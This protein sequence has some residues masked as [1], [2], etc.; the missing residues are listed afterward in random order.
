MRNPAW[1]GPPS[2]PMS[3]VRGAHWSAQYETISHRTVDAAGRGHRRR[4]GACL[5]S[6]YKLWV[7]AA[8]ADRAAA[9]IAR[10]DRSVTADFDPIAVQRE[11]VEWWAHA[12]ASHSRAGA[13]LGAQRPERPDA[14][15]PRGADNLAVMAGGSGPAGVA[16]LYGL[17]AERD[18]VR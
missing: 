14:L 16:S 8:A 18:T 6:S 9:P 5:R 13:P 3:G 4:A 7:H 2:I 12:A 10:A 17:A 1:R 11:S 15:A